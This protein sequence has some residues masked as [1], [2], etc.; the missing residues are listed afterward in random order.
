MCIVSFH[1]VQ[2]KLLNY[3]FERYLGC[4]LII[5]L[6]CNHQSQSVRDIQLLW[7]VINPCKTFGIKWFFLS[8]FF[9]LICALVHNHLI[10]YYFQVLNVKKMSNSLISVI[11]SIFPGR[12]YSTITIIFVFYIHFFNCLYYSLYIFVTW[13]WSKV[14]IISST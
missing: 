7:Y 5:I 6:A 11:V 12:F 4:Y 14:S 8:W 2:I 13:V 9:N 1:L 10:K 3:L